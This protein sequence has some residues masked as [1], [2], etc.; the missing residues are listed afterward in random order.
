MPSLFKKSP[1]QKRQLPPRESFVLI[2]ARTDTSFPNYVVVVAT[3]LYMVL[4]CASLLCR[5]V[6]L[7]FNG[8]AATVWNAFLQTWPHVLLGF[9]GVPANSNDLRITLVSLW[10]LLWFFFLFVLRFTIRVARDLYG[11]CRA[12]WMQRSGNAPIAARKHFLISHAPWLSQNITDAPSP[13]ALLDLLQQGNDWSHVLAEILEQAPQEKRPPVIVFISVSE[14]LTVSIIGQDGKQEPVEFDNPSWKAVL[15]FFAFKR[16]GEWVPRKT[17]QGQIY[18]A[19]GGKLLDLHTSRINE[20]VNEVATNAGF[21][22][23]LE[24]EEKQG[25][26][27]LFEHDKKQHLWRLSPRCEVE[28]FSDLT[29][30]HEQILAAQAGQMT[31][32]RNVLRT[33]CYQVLMRYGKGLLAPYQKPHQIWPWLREAYITY[34]E[35]FIRILDYAALCEWQASQEHVHSDLA[36][37]QDAIWHS[38][39][40]SG[41]S[42]LVALE[43]ASRLDAGEPALIRSLEGY[44]LL[45]DIDAAGNIYQAY[46]ERMHERDSRWTPSLKIREIWPEVTQLHSKERGDEKRKRYER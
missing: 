36:E 26:L 41:R 15:A 32:S 8:T 10:M 12:S 11:L 22:D 20:K 19:E 31:L 30:L 6:V 46:V 38:A 14:H 34:R 24:F 33:R 28:I 44:Y 7:I 21:L 1:L 40:F 35:Q 45:K 23:E 13:T 39:R 42:A 25:K 18:G 17:A 9:A 3:L 2:R 27:D 16:K 37:C 43:F 29:A 5:L 4:L